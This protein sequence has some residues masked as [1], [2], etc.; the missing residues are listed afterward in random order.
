MSPP[1]SRLLTAADAVAFQRL[2]LNAL[3]ESPEAF[4]SVL[5]DEQQKATNRFAQELTYASLIAP[6][7]YYG[8]FIEKQ[9]VGY[10]LISSTFLGKQRHVAFLY[11]LY[12]N[13]SY[14][15]R[16]FA[17]QLVQFTLDLLREHQVEWLYASCISTNQAAQVFYQ[18]MGFVE[19]GRRPSSV[20][21]DDAYADEVELALKI[22]S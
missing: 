2:R 14:R 8:C 20:K 5:A 18:K 10:V 15:H 12:F 4:L 19:Y 7:G 6:F 3:E 1:T 13:P 21:D 22:G 16:G 9:L 17:S 11:N